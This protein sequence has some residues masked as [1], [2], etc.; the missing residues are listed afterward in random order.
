M[1]AYHGQLLRGDNAA[2]EA[3]GPPVIAGPTVAAPSA[4]MPL[5]LVAPAGTDPAEVMRVRRSIEEQLPEG[6]GLRDDRRMS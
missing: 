5:V 3:V 4:E 2:R 6:Y 1:A